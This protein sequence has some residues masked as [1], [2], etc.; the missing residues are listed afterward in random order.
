[1]AYGEMKIWP[2]RKLK[3]KEKRSTDERTGTA[4]NLKRERD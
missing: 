1:V 4:T 3:N 2:I